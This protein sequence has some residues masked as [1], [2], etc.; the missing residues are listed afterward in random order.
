MPH[1]RRREGSPVLQEVVPPNAAAVSSA[2]KKSPVIELSCALTPA[3]PRNSGL[4]KAGAKAVLVGPP[5]PPALPFEVVESRI[6]VPAVSAASGC[7][8]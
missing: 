6:R 7:A 8:P 2:R 3:E 1:T 5:A 4:R